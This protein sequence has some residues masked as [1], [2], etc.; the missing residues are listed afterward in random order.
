LNSAGGS[1]TAGGGGVYHNDLATWQFLCGVGGATDDQ[2]EV[3]FKKAD[4]LAVKM[5]VAALGFEPCAPFTPLGSHIR[6]T[7]VCADD[8]HGRNR[9]DS[10]SF[11]R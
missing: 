3:T 6:K 1:F 5:R 10:T 11:D 7:R 8:V 4:E 2:A 9:P